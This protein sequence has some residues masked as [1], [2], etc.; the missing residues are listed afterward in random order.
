VCAPSALQAGAQRISQP[1]TP[2]APR[3][4]GGPWPVSQGVANDVHRDPLRATADL[5]VLPGEHNPSESPPLIVTRTFGVRLSRKGGVH[6]SAIRMGDGTGMGFPRPPKNGG[7]LRPL[8]SGEKTP[9]AGDMSRRF[10]DLVALGASAAPM[11][12]SGVLLSARS[13]PVFYLPH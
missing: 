9:F 5:D 4:M 11:R 6:L 2:D 8:M 3:L 1:P 12:K 7:G 10:S 13:T